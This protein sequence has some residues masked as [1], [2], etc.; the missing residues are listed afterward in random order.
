MTV[1]KAPG[2]ALYGSRAKDGVIMITTRT[3]APAKAS[4][5]STTPTLRPTSRWT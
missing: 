3:K 1:L 4:A 5:W 2:R